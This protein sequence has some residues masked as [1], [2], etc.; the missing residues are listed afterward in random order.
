MGCMMYADLGNGWFFDYQVYP[1]SRTGNWVGHVVDSNAARPSVIYQPWAW[2]GGTGPL[3]GNLLLE[4]VGTSRDMDEGHPFPGRVHVDK[5]GIAA[6]LGHLEGRIVGTLDDL[7]EILGIGGISRDLKTF[8]AE[9]REAFI[10][11]KRPIS[12]VYPDWNKAE[13][14]ET[15][16]TA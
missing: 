15:S 6:G 1:P 11:G 2:G 9:E 4:V 8:A 16:A 10:H 12:E 13:P 7:V 5:A 3:G 14:E